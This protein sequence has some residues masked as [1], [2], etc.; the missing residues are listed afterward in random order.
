MKKLSKR[1]L[2]NL[3][4][5]E[6]K[7]IVD[8]EKLLK[9]P[10]SPG[11]HGYAK[12]HFNLEDEYEDDDICYQCGDY[13]DDCIECTDRSGGAVNCIYPADSGSLPYR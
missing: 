8:E 1:E 11:D 13:H 2:T 10:T 9:P 7:R 3:I 12:F 4:K 5:N 6:I